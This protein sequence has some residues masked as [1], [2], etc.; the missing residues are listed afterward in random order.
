[1][2]TDR[3]DL[4]L[5][6]PART[7]LTEVEALTFTGRLNPA[8]FEEA[9]ELYQIGTLTKFKNRFK[10]KLLDFILTND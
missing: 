1:M 2:Y 6:D 8:G 4:S 5:I 10:L 7:G 3:I 9:M